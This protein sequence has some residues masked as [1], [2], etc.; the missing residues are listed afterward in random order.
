ML[1]LEDAIKVKRFYTK[2]KLVIFGN[3]VEL[4]FSRYNELIR[5]NEITSPK[6]VLLISIISSDR[7]SIS[8]RQFYSVFCSNRFSLGV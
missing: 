3:I 4:E 6:S 1:S 7:S 8:L 5:Q 2:N